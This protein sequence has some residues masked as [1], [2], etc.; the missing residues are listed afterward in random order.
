MQKCVATDI[1]FKILGIIF[2][3]QFAIDEQVGNFG[4][5]LLGC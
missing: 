3:W 1:V 4:E 2:A 5:A